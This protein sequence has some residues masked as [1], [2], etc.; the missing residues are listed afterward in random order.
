MLSKKVQGRTYGGFLATIYGGIFTVA[1]HLWLG[2]HVVSA[3]LIF[4]ALWI[5]FYRTGVWMVTE[6][7]AELD[8]KIPVSSKE[9]RTRKKRFY[10]WLDSQGK[11]QH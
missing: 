6:R 11:Q 2:L 10:E 3:S 7:P 5:G 9:L 8:K 4:I 1:I